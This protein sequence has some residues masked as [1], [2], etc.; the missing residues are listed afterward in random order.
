MDAFVS[1]LAEIS[2]SNLLTLEDGTR[3]AD[4]FQ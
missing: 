1:L 4:L 2:M 3:G